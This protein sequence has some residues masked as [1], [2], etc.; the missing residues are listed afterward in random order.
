MRKGI[1]AVL[2]VTFL[3][4]APTMWAADTLPPAESTLPEEVVITGDRRLFS[5]RTRMF[6]AEKRAYDLFNELN[7]EKRFDIHCST[8]QPT[9]TRIERQICTPYFQ[10]EANAVSARGYW[11][12]LRDHLDPF[13][14]EGTTQNVYMNAETRI[15]SQQKDYQQKLRQIAEQHPEF[16]DAISEYT[17]VRRHYE[18]A[19]TSSPP[20]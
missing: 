10:I 18:E 19:A 17:A 4:S 15:A 7:H 8:H 5:L 1:P 16:L 2:L 12:S 20:E 14:T 9:G 3:V 13:S 6:E 11:E